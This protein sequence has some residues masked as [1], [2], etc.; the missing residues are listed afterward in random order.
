MAAMEVTQ[1]KHTI[2][3]KS[4]ESRMRHVPSTK[5]EDGTT[6]SPAQTLLHAETVERRKD[7]GL[8]PTTTFL[9]SLHGELFEER[10]V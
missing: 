1:A 3:F 9:R 4:M 10:K 7:A 6:V 8:F 2:G 5:P